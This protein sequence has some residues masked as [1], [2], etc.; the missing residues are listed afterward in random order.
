MSA[1]EP[2]K[3]AILCQNRSLLFYV[4]LS[5]DLIILP[6]NAAISTCAPLAGLTGTFPRP[7]KGLH[8]PQGIDLP[9]CNPQFPCITSYGLPAFSPANC[10][11]PELEHASLS[12][13]N[14]VRHPI[15]LMINSSPWE[16]VFEKGSSPTISRP[17]QPRTRS[18]N[19]RAIH[20]EVMEF[21]W[22]RDPSMHV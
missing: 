10:F 12:K 18:L 19:D 14:G 21:I 2:Y 15:K 9:V 8:F 6:Y 13:I 11:L 16:T 1:D 4:M 20:P 5:L 17:P 7:T 3:T 22:L